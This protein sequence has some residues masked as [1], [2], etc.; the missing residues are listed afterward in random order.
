MNKSIFIVGKV[1]KQYILFLKEKGYNVC[2]FKDKKYQSKLLNNIDEVYDVDFSTRESIF[3]SLH[4]L[5]IQS[6]PLCLVSIYE[7][8]I[9]PKAW[10]AEYFGVDS[11]TVASAEAAT[12]KNI[13]RTYFLRHDPSL[14]PK[15]KKVETWHDVETFLYDV[16]FPLIL[17]PANLQKSLLVM[18]SDT[19]EQLKENFEYMKDN[20]HKIYKKYFVSNRQPSM[21]LEEF[22]IGSFHSVECFADAK[23]NVTALDVVDLVMASELGIDDNYNYS[24]TLPSRMSV[25]KQKELKHAAIQAVK[26]LD[27]RYSPAHVELVYT[28][29]GAKVIEVGARLGGYR[30]RM[31]SFA[32]GLNLYD[33]E[34]DTL[35]GKLPDF[36]TKHNHHCIVYEL[37][38]E[39]KGKLKEIIGL[40]KVKNLSTLRYISCPAHVD[41]EVGLSKQG[42]KAVLIVIL[43]STD[44]NIIQKEKSIIEHEVKITVETTGQS[45]LQKI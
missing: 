23:G 21:I 15:F 31:F 14:T 26:A 9:M 19:K 39:K 41:D 17:K 32:Y 25:E 13:M 35:L 7:N 16:E 11:I 12:D 45:S 1:F 5:D 37:F 10:I 38:P 18:K 29:N 22:L 34:L 36:E 43:S 2:L 44:Q 28:Q 40:E 6:K 8:Y 24:R 27:F 3:Q 30:K 33:I 4:N 20:I 42:F